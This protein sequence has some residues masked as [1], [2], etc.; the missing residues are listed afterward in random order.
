M[1]SHRFL[2]AL[3]WKMGTTRNYSSVRVETS[4]RF[5]RL[6]KCTHSLNFYLR[7]HLNLNLSPLAPWISSPSRTRTRTRTRTQTHTHTDVQSAGVPRREAHSRVLLPLHLRICSSTPVCAPCALPA[8]LLLLR[9][10]LSS[11][12]Q[13]APRTRRR[14]FRHEREAEKLFRALDR[15]RRCSLSLSSKISSAH[16]DAILGKISSNAIV[17]RA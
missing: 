11:A 15:S 16:L 9:I 4:T 12:A 17:S 3:K 5:M 13:C 1:S 8:S 10:R 7:L 6:A 2:D 14:A